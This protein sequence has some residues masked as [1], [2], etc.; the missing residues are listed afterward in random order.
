MQGISR[1]K[2]SSSV[3]AKPQAKPQA[4]FK[5]KVKLF[6][7]QTSSPNSSSFI[8]KPQAKPQANTP[9]VFKPKLINWALLLLQGCRRRRRRTSGSSPR[10][11]STFPSWSGWS[12]SWRGPATAAR[13]RSWPRW[14]ACARDAVQCCRENRCRGTRMLVLPCFQ[15]S[16]A[17]PD[18]SWKDRR[19]LFQKFGA[20]RWKIQNSKMENW[21]MAT[22][23]L[24]E[25]SKCAGFYFEW[26]EHST[27]FK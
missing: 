3:Q 5:L 18:G 9:E 17:C 26:D 11:A 15:L 4:A 8:A 1:S 14:R 10:C 22:D 16:K 20:P 21:Y 27:L 2:N 7:S 24:R 13:R 23:G 6:Q 19:F 12:R 25:V